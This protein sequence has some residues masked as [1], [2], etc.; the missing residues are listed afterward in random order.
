MSTHHR[1]RLS[2]KSPGELNARPDYF[3]TAST[4]QMPPPA[5]TPTAGATPQHKQHHAAFSS[6]SSQTFNANFD[7]LMRASSSSSSTSPGHAPPP[8]QTPLHAPASSPF[9]SSTE[10]STN[11][12]GIRGEAAPSHNKGSAM[13][14]TTMAASSIQPTHAPPAQSEALPFKMPFSRRTSGAAGG[15]NAVKSTRYSLF[16]PQRLAASIL[17]ASS[18]QPGSVPGSVPELLIL[19]IRTRSAFLHER[20]A[21]SIN[22]C[23]PSTLL[24]RPAYDVDRVQDSLPAYDQQR[25]EHWRS[26]RCRAIVVLDQ[27]SAALIE[28]AGPVSLLAKFDHA[29]FEGEL[30]WVKGGWNAVRNGL[31]AIAPSL[32][33]Q[34]RL[35]EHGERQ[36]AFDDEEGEEQD[37]GPD[38]GE[39]ESP[40][41]RARLS[42]ASSGMASSAPHSPGLTGIP[43]SKK[44]ARAGVTTTSTTSSASSATSS[45][46][47]GS[48][49]PSRRPSMSMHSSSTYSSGYGGGSNSSAAAGGRPVLQVRDLPMS[50]FQLSSTTA[51]RNSGGPMTGSQG[52]GGAAGS[53]DVDMSG[54]SSSSSSN[55]TGTGF[56]LRQPPTGGAT[57]GMGGKRL[58]NARFNAPPSLATS[59]ASAFARA[60][61]PGSGGSGPQTAGFQSH[62]QRNGNGNELSAGWLSTSSAPPHQPRGGGGGQIRA[63]ANPFFDNIRQNTEALSLERSLANLTPVNLPPV[64]S[65]YLAALPPYLRSLVALSPMSRADRLA[66]Q[67]YELEAA[68]RE[69]LEGTFRWHSRYPGGRS[70]AIREWQQQQQSEAEEGTAENEAQ[71]R[72]EAEKWERFGIS[73]GVEL[74][75]LNRFRNIFPYEHSR[76][77]LQEHSPNATDYV[78][79]S[80]LS[81]RTSSKRFIASQ[82]PLPSTFRDFWQM[83]EQ[84]HVGVIVMLTNLQEGGRDKCG[85]YWVEQHGGEWDVH[86]EGDSAHEEEARRAFVP[87]T[88]A[89]AAPPPV[90]AGADP[91]AGGGF[92]SAFDAAKTAAPVKTPGPSSDATIR[93]TITV[94]RRQGVGA[95]GTADAS[96]APSRKI[97]HIQYRAWPDFDI[98]ADPSDVVSLVDEVDAAQRDYMR[99]I[100]WD[101]AEHAGQE[102]P[103]LAHCSAGVGRTGVFIMVSS[104]LDKFRSERPQGAATGSKPEQ[105]VSMDIDG[106][107]GAG[108]E[109]QR[110]PS[111]PALEERLSDG[112]A[113]SLAAGL[114]DSSLDE[115]KRASDLAALAA[116]KQPRLPPVE[117]PALTQ[118][119]PAFA[120][121][122]ELRE[123]RM[124]MVANYRQYVCVLECVLEGAL[125][126]LNDNT[127]GESSD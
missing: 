32:E 74:G 113:S 31:V 111:R 14:T 36:D 124:S 19:D 85:R 116:G 11:G 27:E 45:H 125:R 112:V 96:V 4:A 82:G 99:E 66:R 48:G 29:G 46:D 15:A 35:L 51:Y 65:N 30:G 79:A 52:G 69:R 68:E 114:S 80:H 25:F 77:R 16:S 92:F 83:C 90:R 95:A 43:G 64:P 63:S 70:E 12:P 60:G 126:T 78:N 120:G 20:L 72:A 33:E 5:A 88:P 102:P 55:P 94:Q 108:E 13:T 39:G 98:P 86:V 21:G 59:H 58:K 2:P 91:A 8:P 47:S 17:A 71:V 23:V 50:A 37:G 41:T 115:R 75:N 22:V 122:N 38:Y 24:R 104:L 84:E 110:P 117:E 3:V 6:P 119:E 18:A 123:Q 109:P 93:R 34:E 101:P 53:R 1:P 107:S 62:S 61:G 54:A 121:V 100:G 9:F 42:L 97:R 118:D 103:I 73:A 56:T 57:T 7:S 40:A 49:R 81:L 106:G 76:V 67:F 89:A 26:E 10:S 105:Q 87:G 28:G 44:H 127:A